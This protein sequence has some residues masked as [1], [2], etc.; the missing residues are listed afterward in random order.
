MTGVFP[1]LIVAVALVEVVLGVIVVVPK[2]VDPEND[3]YVGVVGGTVVEYSKEKVDAEFVTPEI[4]KE[5]V[6]LEQ[7]IYSVD[8]LDPRLMGDGV[9]VNVEEATAEQPPAVVPRTW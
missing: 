5:V 3:T 7:N 9:T 8:V 2:D 6:R 4:G 1:Q